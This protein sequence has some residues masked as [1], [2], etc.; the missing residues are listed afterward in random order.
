[1][2]ELKTSYLPTRRS[3]LRNMGAAACA[4]VA[5]F[6]L[7][8]AAASPV[9]DPP[10]SFLELIRQPDE[11]LAFAEE[12][13]QITLRRSGAAWTGRDVRLECE[14]KAG[15]LRLR[16]SAPSTALLRIH[17]RWKAV[18][19]SGL[20][21]L[22]D[23]WER[24]YGELGWRQIVPERPMPWYFLAFDGKTTHGYGVRTG[25]AVLAFWQCD[26]EGVS[27]W[28][29]LRNGGR[30]VALGERSLDAATVVAHQGTAGEDPF[31]AAQALCR[32][33]SP[34]P[35]LPNA[36][37]YGSNDWYYAYGKSSADDILRDADLVAELAPGSGPRPF[38][39]IDEGW[40]NNPRFP[41]MNDLAREIRRKGVR[42][43]L[44]VRP[45]RARGETNTALLLPAERFG[46]RAERAPQSQAYDPTIPE[47]RQKALDKIRQAAAWTYELV[48]HDFSTFDLLG[49][50][51]NEM[52]ASPTLP[53]WSFHDR[54]QT[55]AEIIRGFYEEIRQSAGKGTII[56]GCNVVGHLSAGLFELHRTGDDVSGKIWERTR[57]MGVNTLA[58]RLPQ[59]ATFHTMDPDCIPIMEAVPWPLTKNWLDAV[60]AAGAALIISPG[61]G[62]MTSER[63]QAVRSA[64]AVAAGRGAGA[65]PADWLDSRTPEQWREGKREQSVRYQ[66]L[67]SG[68]AFPFKV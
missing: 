62:S 24:S 6:H 34:S 25:A 44:W 17:L 45:L 50:W 11:A 68:G 9:A 43:G 67:E 26:R 46:P 48:K 52:G 13:E 15:V 8:S 23:A 63:K 10:N 49:Q 54:S 32:A 40:E 33:L 5:A 14:E 60:T 28:L 20:R 55:N 58:F 35:L 38:T 22:G 3:V 66:W 4:G 21:L 7:E 19:P 65:F 29:D 1:M 57:R 42:P 51:G 41:S 16:L 12:P 2:K 37:V 18:V 47:A 36:P 31:R 30:G 59:N 64:F 61:R 27:L 39:V 53:G 56:D